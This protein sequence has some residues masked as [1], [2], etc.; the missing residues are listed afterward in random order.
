MRN[1]LFTIGILPVSKVSV[2]VISVGNLSV[3][4]T[5]KTPHVIYIVELLKEQ[6]KTA[7]LLRGYGRK[8]KGF[9]KVTPNIAVNLVG[10]EAL[11]YARKFHQNVDVA[12]SEDRV[13]GAKKLLESNPS[14]ELIVLDDAYQNRYLHRDC[15]ILLTEYKAPFFNDWVMPSGKLREFRAGKKRADIVIVTKC[16]TDLS[17]TQK[18]DFTKKLQ[19]QKETPVYFSTIRYG[20][21]RNIQSDEVI[22]IPKSV[23]LVTGIGNPEPLQNYLKA[24]SDVKIVKFGDHHHY[25]KEDIDKIHNLFD[26][27]AGQDKVI[28][29]TEKD[30]V[31]LLNS[32]LK[33]YVEKYPWYYQTMEVEIDKKEE[34]KEKIGKYVSS[35]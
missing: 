18:S 29:T 31:R 30:A 16:P 9:V 8:S 33:S 17:E 5:G 3:G 11:S 13:E 19:L 26:T 32:S 4:G 21:L 28:V 25:T 6:Y 1:M 7:I 2:P 35:N 27:F 24:F 15:N 23:L 22:E 14:L 10:D 20:A 12:V 34:F